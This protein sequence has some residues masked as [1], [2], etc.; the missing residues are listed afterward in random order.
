M[1]LKSEIKEFGLTSLDMDCIGVTDV[2][3]L[4]GASE[5]FKQTPV[6]DHR[7]PQIHTD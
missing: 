7:F 5:R 3:R 2:E 6:I 4:S 1:D